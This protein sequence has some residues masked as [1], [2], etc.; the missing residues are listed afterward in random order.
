[1]S[2]TRMGSMIP[3]PFEKDTPQSSGNALLSLLSIVSLLP[4]C[5][6]QFTLFWSGSMGSATT[7]VNRV[8]TK[9]AVR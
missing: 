3:L 8:S 7:L 1:M 6:A 5:A 2:F 9:D 4:L